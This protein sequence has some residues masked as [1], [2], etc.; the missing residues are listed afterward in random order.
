MEI[1]RRTKEEEPISPRRTN[2]GVDDDLVTICLKCLEKDFAQRYVSA[3]ALA[4]DLERW[5][6]RESIHARR[7]SIIRRTSRWVQR[8]NVGTA[9]I[10][11]LCISLAG[12]LLLLDKLRQAN[13]VASRGQNAL[14]M[15]VAMDQFWRSDQ[16]MAEISSEK[17]AVIT[18]RE[19]RDRDKAITNRFRMGFMVEADPSVRVQKFAPIIGKI[20]EEVGRRL[21]EPIRLDLCVY[22]R[23][24]EAINDLVAGK[25]DFLR[26][27]GVS[28]LQAKA[29]S[30]GVVPI[31]TQAPAKKAIIF[32]STNSGIKSMADLK[33]RSFA[34]GESYAT[35]SFWAKYHLATNGITGA[36]LK[37]YELYSVAFSRVETSCHGLCFARFSRV[38][39]KRH[40]THCNL[41]LLLTTDKLAKNWPRKERSW[42]LIKASKG[43]QVEYTPTSSPTLCSS[44]IPS[45]PD[46]AELPAQRGHV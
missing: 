28:Y 43:R 1:L 8:N 44:Y 6:R 31:A 14:L 20:E 29:L 12:A 5:L 7:T 23:N 32:A 27:G 15:D 46:C 2:P 24:Q 10:A 37:H 34:F 33:G 18:G 4:E 40:T 3:E 13:E 41:I 21:G 17:L 35:I 38:F 16:Q 19:G 45:R 9:L 26:I 22:K 42:A 36:E 30:P 11:T 25:L 39:R